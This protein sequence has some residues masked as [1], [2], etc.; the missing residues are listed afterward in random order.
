M[1]TAAIEAASAVRKASRRVLPLLGAMYVVSFLDRANLGYAELRMNA[2]IGLSTAAYGLGVGMFFIGYSL[3]EVPS[4]LILH[5]VGARKWMTRIAVTWGVL[6]SAM[7]FIDSPAGFYAV[8]FLL[9]VAE[10]GFFPGLVLYLTY[11]F[12]RRQR[13]KIMS[14]LTLAVPTALALGGLV[15]TWLME[16]GDGFLGFDA[17]WRTMFFV[18]GLPAIGLGF[19]C[20]GLLPD[21][22][23][24]ARWLTTPERQAL[25]ETIEAEDHAHVPSPPGLRQSLLHP[26][27]LL[28]CL[29]YFGIVYGLYALTFFLPQIISDLQTNFGVNF[30]LVQIGLISA[31]PYGLG[32]VAMLWNARHSDRAFERVLHVVVPTFSGAVGVAAA[33]YFR[34]P[35]LALAAL[36]VCAMGVLAAL[37]VFWQLPTAFLGGAGAAAAIGLINTS[38]NLSGFVAPYITGW[39]HDLTGDFRAGMWAVAGFMTI[40]ALLTLT[41]RPRPGT[42]TPSGSP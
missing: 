17:G 2:D 10:A 4:N 35:Y 39:L 18:E 22:P 25:T 1:R 27:V 38:G 8:R 9:G 30:T 41:L 16:Q 32:A 40:A 29:V 26:R 15:S 13:A 7:A 37:P 6:A 11:W 12:P 36:S 33:L 21:R 23:R 24:Y 19:A 3:F 20:W 5:K 31:I 42:D 28:L 14:L 34:S